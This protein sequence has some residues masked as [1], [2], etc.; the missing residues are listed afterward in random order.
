MEPIKSMNDLQIAISRLEMKQ[1]IEGKLLKEAFHE[2]VGALTPANLILKTVRDISG[3][4]KLKD[5]FVN[6]SVGLLTGFI[7][8]KVFEKFSDMPMKKT[9]GT[10]IMF[11]INYLISKNPEAIRNLSDR[12][13][14]LFRSGKNSNATPAESAETDAQ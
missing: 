12:F 4:E 14:Q 7:S 2:L 3:S 8:K 9:M 1:E 6:I 11:G 5:E 13:F 10:A